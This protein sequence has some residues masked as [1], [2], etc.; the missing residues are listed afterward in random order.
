M[1]L[2]FNR[3]TVGVVLV[4]LFVA[5]GMAHVLNDSAIAQAPAGR[6]S[7]GQ[8]QISAYAGPTGG[9]GV[10][11]GCYIVDTSTGEVWHSRSGGTVE[12]VSGSLQ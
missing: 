12:K 11:H 1:A 7:V 9:G 6:S 2:S 8:Y 5:I 10:H 3:W 4:L